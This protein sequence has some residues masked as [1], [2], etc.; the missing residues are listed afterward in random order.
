MKTIKSYCTIWLSILLSC[1]L[2]SS[3]DEEWGTDKSLYDLAGEW[4]VVE[5]SNL[6][7]CQ[8]YDRWIF[9]ADWNFA[10]YNNNGTIYSGEWDCN[11][12]T[13]YIRFSS[14]DPEIEA[15]VLEYTGD[16]LVLEVNDYGAGASYTLR[17]VRQNYYSQAKQAD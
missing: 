12:R 10:M 1:L 14:Y 3:C 7:I 2:L 4:Q 6:Q 15:Y 8:P 9:G 5:S 13:V 16:Y 11:Q 17:L